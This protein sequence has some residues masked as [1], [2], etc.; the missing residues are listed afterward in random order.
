MKRVLKELVSYS[1]EERRGT[2]VGVN[3]F[4]GALL[5]ANLGA[6][7]KLPL[8]E[9]AQLVIML[10]GVITSMFTIVAS[11]RRLVVLVTSGLLVWILG[12][13]I[14]LSDELVPAEAVADLHRM[15]V[16]LLIWVVFTVAIKL[17]PAIRDGEPGPPSGG[18]RDLVAEEG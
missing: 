11:R 16:T 7:E 13:M 10:C 5:G 3:L 6:T 2:M 12:A 15:L 8:A 4:F 9:Y 14:Y 18:K 17:T 1:D